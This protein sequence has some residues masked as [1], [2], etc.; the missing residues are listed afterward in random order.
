M[1][2]SQPILSMQSTKI[3]TITYGCVGKTHTL[4]KCESLQ[5]TSN[6]HSLIFPTQ[7]CVEL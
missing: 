5:C 2:P 3:E 7:D 4:E 6:G 1:T